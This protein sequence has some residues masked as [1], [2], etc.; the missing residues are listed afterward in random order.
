MSVQ[1][2]ANPAAPSASFV[3]GKS[4]SPGDQLTTYD[5]KVYVYVQA[6][7][8]IGGD[9]YVVTIDGDYQAA[10]LDTD[11]DALGDRI[12]VAEAA[13]EDNDYGWVQIYGTCGIFT[14]AEA[15][16]NTRMAATATGGQ[17]DDA[18]AAGSLY[19][20][21][22]ILET[23]TGAGEAAVNESGVLNFPVISTVPATA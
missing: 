15:A 13:F 1:I 7:G 19:I 22:M 17:V 20:Q 5:G 14:A 18:G 21:G 3:D 2:G 16:A 6:S 4:F 10:E 23:A 9:G 8:A 11:N 12:G